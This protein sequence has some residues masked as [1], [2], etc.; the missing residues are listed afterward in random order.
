MQN[1]IAVRVGHGRENVEEQPETRLDARG[2]RVTPHVYWHA[3][4]DLQ[5]QIGLITC[6]DTGVEQARNIWVR[7]SREQVT[8]AR[9]ALHTTT[10]KQSKIQKLD[11]Y[12]CLVAAIAAFRPPDRPHPA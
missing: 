1:Q 9:E 12:G 11:G 8:F 6:R 10:L 5:H 4:D 3:V 2:V 7:Q